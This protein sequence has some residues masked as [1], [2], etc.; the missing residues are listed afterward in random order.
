MERAMN[1]LIGT[2]QSGFEMLCSHLHYTSFELSHHK[3]MEKPYLLHI[4]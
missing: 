4:L 2:Q 1:N 3:S